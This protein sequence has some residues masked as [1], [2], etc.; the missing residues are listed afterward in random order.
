MMGDEYVSDDEESCLSDEDAEDMKKQ[1][2]DEE[3]SGDIEPK[4]DQQQQPQD[5]DNDGN[6]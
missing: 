6:N 2:S 3:S 1:I 4:D 5:G